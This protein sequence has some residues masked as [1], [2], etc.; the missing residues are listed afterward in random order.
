MPKVLLGEQARAEAR[1]LSQNEALCWAIKT[2]KARLGKTY[3]A[4]ADAVGITRKLLYQ[5]TMPEV[6]SNTRFGI[7]RAVAHEIGMTREEWLKLGGF[8]K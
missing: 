8:E 5:L 7:V 6:V 2:V 3:T 1:T 4:T